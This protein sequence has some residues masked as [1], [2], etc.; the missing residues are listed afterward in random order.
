MQLH[1]RHYTDAVF[2]STWLNLTRPLTLTGTIGPAAAGTLWLARGS[3]PDLL[4]FI[5]FLAAS[6]LVQ[7]AANILNDYFDF[8]KGQDADKWTNSGEGPHHRELLYGGALLIA[9][10]LPFGLYIALTSG[11]AV[12]IA[13]ALS[14]GAA[15]FYSAGK[16]SLASIALGEMTAAMFLGAVMTL[17]SFSI[18]QAPFD[19]GIVL[20]AVIFAA[21]IASMILTNNIRDI[22]KDRPF[23]RTIPLLIGRRASWHLLIAFTAVPYSVLAAG[24]IAGIF[25]AVSAM[26]VLAL[27]LT[28][29]LLY[30][31][32]MNA[33]REEEISAMKT[34]ALQHWSFSGLLIGSFVLML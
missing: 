12:V 5:L 32:R 3:S 30:S 23:R 34:A 10:S 26:A 11:T 15:V 14:L 22:E 33:A 25:P 27:P 21:L 31:L 16:Y 19:T 29:K 24:I 17:L 2:K 9:L 6:L 4:R 28:G 20:L 13:G 8:K 7:I 1:E 18:Q